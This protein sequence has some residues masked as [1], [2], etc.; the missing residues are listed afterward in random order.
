[1]SWAPIGVWSAS[2][3]LAIAARWQRE[4]MPAATLLTHSQC[5][6]ESTWRSLAAPLA[7]VVAEVGAGVGTGAAQALLAA[8]LRYGVL[9]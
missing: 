8:M 6:T 4:V 1:M 7:L 2:H 9:A 3:P 5:T